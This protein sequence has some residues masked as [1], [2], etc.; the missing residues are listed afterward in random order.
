M[1]EANSTPPIAV[2]KTAKPNKPYLELPLFAHP[3]GVWAKKVRGTL[4]YFAPEAGPGA[5]WRR[6]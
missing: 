1:S 4:H 2:G 3:G 5:H 6:T